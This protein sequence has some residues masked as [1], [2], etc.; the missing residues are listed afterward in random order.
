MKINTIVAINIKLPIAPAI[1]AN[2]PIIEFI[3][4][5]NF[6]AKSPLDEI[7]FCKKSGSEDVTWSPSFVNSIVNVS[8]S[9]RFEK[10][11]ACCDI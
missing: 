4:S 11:L 2:D 5:L 8:L 10:S 1:E 7:I 9:I 6:P 3:N